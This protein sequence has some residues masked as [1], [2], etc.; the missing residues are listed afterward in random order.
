M[1]SCWGC[2]VIRM[3]GEF[4]PIKNP[5][6][7]TV[8]FL[9]K[10]MKRNGNRSW[11]GICRGWK[12]GSRMQGSVGAGQKKRYEEFLYEE[13][14]EHILKYGIACYKKRCKVVLLDDGCD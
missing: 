9:W 12:P 8:I 13:D 5:E 3:D 14:I 4:P 11:D 2:W 7:G 6:M 10:L 1:V